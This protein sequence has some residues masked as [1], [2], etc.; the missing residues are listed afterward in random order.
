M[1]KESRLYWSIRK[2]VFNQMLK[3]RKDGWEPTK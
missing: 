2:E 1:L 3:T